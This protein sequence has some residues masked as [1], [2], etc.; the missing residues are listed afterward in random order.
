MWTVLTFEGIKAPRVQNGQTYH[1]SCV[2][3]SKT[4]IFQ[5]SG[6]RVSGTNTECILN[7]LYCSVHFLCEIQTI[8]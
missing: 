8:V 7:K 5:S 4:V 1:N 3:P 2:A 6:V